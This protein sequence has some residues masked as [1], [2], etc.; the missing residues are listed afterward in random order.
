M[1]KF[2]MSLAV[3]AAMLLGSGKTFGC[4]THGYVAASTV[5]EMVNAIPHDGIDIQVS[6]ASGLKLSDPNAVQQMIEKNGTDILDEHTFI[7]TINGV[8]H[9]FAFG[10]QAV[11]DALE[12][13]QQEIRDNRAKH[14]GEF[15]CS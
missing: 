14:G 10:A 11:I 2:L 1:N 9:Q 8:E 3:V 6:V 12:M 7:I 15:Y 5:E 4:S 13:I